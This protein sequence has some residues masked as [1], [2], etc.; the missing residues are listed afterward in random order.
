MGEGIKTRRGES[1]GVASKVIYDSGQENESI[2]LNWSRGTYT[3]EKLAGNIHSY[4]YYPTYMEWNGCGYG[5]VSGIDFTKY[6]TFNVTFSNNTNPN[7]TYGFLIVR[8]QTGK[9]T[10]PTESADIRLAETRKDGSPVV[11]SYT[12]SVDISSIS[13][14]KW[15]EIVTGGC[16]G[17]VHAYATK[18]WLE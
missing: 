15:F 4:G 7:S 8:I 18:I 5:N 10:S 9:P 6:K 17:G 14:Q 3:F 13:G 11:G 12:M 1:K 2:S 16:S